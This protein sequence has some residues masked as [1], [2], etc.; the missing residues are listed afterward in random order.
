MKGL[1]GLSSIMSGLMGARLSVADRLFLCVQNANSLLS[2]KCWVILLGDV[3]TKSEAKSL[4][5]WNAQYLTGLMKK[6]VCVVSAHL[7][8]T[9][10]CL[11]FQLAELF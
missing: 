5:S 6:P 9:Y 2:P 10:I 7:L 4:L 3:H 1:R 8:S 11:K